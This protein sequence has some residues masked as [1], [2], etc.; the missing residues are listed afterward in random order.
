RRPRHRARGIGGACGEQARRAFRCRRR[1]DRTGTA[2]RQCRRTEG[3]V[4]RWHPGS[5]AFRRQWLMASSSRNPDNTTAA[6]DSSAKGRVGALR[7]LWPFV[8]R[9]RA[10]FIAWLVALA[11]SSSAT[12]SLPIAVRYMIDRGFSSAGNIDAAFGLLLVVALALA[13][14]T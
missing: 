5:G 8:M 1:T 11:A 4:A 10:L 2:C 13:F 3:Q 14:A 12:L 9:H 6:M 7:M